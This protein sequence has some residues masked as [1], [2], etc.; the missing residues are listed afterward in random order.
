M[1]AYTC[2][3]CRETGHNAARHKPWSPPRKLTS[4]SMK[5]TILVEESGCTL[6]E[7]AEQCGVTH[8]A[9]SQ[10]WTRRFPDRPVPTEERWTGWRDQVPTL[11]ALQM[12]ADEIAAKIGACKST[13]QRIAQDAGITLRNPWLIHPDAITDA[14]A[15]IAAGA[16]VAEAAADY[17]ISFG[18]LAD[19]SRERGVRSK[20]TGRG[21]KDGR[22]RR[23]FQRVRAGASIAAACAAERCAP[24]GVSNMLRREEAGQ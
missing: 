19:L 11:A 6:R 22:S 16:T 15:A 9:V 1:T 24:C 23:A 2:R 8:Q 14:L 10:A 13:V 5:A 7:A 21:R 18:R 12:T 3:V 4:R 17:G 20:A